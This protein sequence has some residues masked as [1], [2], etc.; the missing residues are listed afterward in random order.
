MVQMTEKH[1]MEP[2]QQK[3]DWCE[4]SNNFL[5]SALNQINKLNL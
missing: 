1:I 4:T 5:Y 3:N 2:L